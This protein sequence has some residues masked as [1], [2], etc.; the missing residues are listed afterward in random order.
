MFSCVIWGP[1][2]NKDLHS[3]YRASS[4][5]HSRLALSNRSISMSK[6]LAQSLYTIY[7]LFGLVPS[8]VPSLIFGING[9]SLTLTHY[10]ENQST[11]Q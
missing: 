6:S 9:I 10:I 4:I 7:H 11:Y 5:W 3:S 8:G 1:M 2:K